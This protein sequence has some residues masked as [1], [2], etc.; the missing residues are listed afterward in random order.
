MKIIRL[1]TQLFKSKKIQEGLFSTAL[2]ETAIDFCS[3]MGYK[4]ANKN[5]QN[6]LEVPAKKTD[7]EG[8][9]I[10]GSEQYKIELQKN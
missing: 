3:E 8:D 2:N 5:V 6:S 9:R 10:P 7:E 1:I 4:L